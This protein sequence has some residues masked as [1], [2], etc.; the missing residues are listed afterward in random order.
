MYYFLSIFPIRFL[1][2]KLLFIF[3][4]LQAN[5]SFFQDRK[6]IS[7]Y[8]SYSFLSFPFRHLILIL[9][10]FFS[11]SLLSHSHFV[12]SFSLLS[13]S[14]SFHFHFLLL[15]S[16]GSLH[17]YSCF[18]TSQCGV[19]QGGQSVSCSMYIRDHISKCIIWND[20]R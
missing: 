20:A 14:F 15:F 8:S 11:F 5:Y 3:F 6:L 4:L 7:I 16:G 13:F 18:A 1:S 9:F 2:H 19:D 17:E 12:I 10:H